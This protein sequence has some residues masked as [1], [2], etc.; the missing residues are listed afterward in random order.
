MAGNVWTAEQLDAIRH[1]GGA[2]LASAAAGSGKTAT[3]AA[4]CASLVLDLPETEPIRGGRADCS[5]NELL[6]VTFTDDASAEMSHRIATTIVRYA[7]ENPTQHNLRQ[8]LLAPAAEVSTLHGFCVRVLRQHGLAM[9]LQPDFAVADDTEANRHRQQAFSVV[10]RKHYGGGGANA[11]GFRLLVE[12]YCDGTL[13]WL[14]DIVKRVAAIHGVVPDPANWDA[15]SLEVIEELIGADCLKSPVIARG[16]AE[17]ATK[18]ETYGAK[19]AE[20]A[21]SAKAIGGDKLQRFIQYTAGWSE[22]LLTAA[23]HVRKSDLASAVHAFSQKPQGNRPAKTKLWPI[24]ATCLAADLESFASGSKFTKSGEALSAW[25]VSAIRRDANKVLPYARQ[26]LAVTADYEAEYARLKRAAGVVDFNDLERFT[27]QLLEV[28]NEETGRATVRDA[29]RRKYKHVLVDE[30]QDINGVQA[31]ILG[32]LCGPEGEVAGAAQFAVGD[33]KQSIYRFRLADPGQFMEMER[34]YAAGNGG[35]LLHMSDNFRSREPVLL[36]VNELFGQL[37]VGGAT[38]IDYSQGHS[39]KAGAAYPAKDGHAVQ[40][41]VLRN[42]T[43][44]NAGEEQVAEGEQPEA[45]AA[46]GSEGDTPSDE[47]EIIL[48]VNLLKE[49]VGRTKVLDKKTGEMRLLE[50]GDCAILL[51]AVRAISLQLG[52]VLRGARIPFVNR[53]A[54]PLLDQ[55]EVQDVLGLLRLATGESEETLWA[56]LLRGPLA[57]LLPAVEGEATEPAQRGSDVDGLLLK[58]APVRGGPGLAAVLSAVAKGEECPVLTGDELHFLQRMVGYVGRLATLTRTLDAAGMLRQIYHDTGYDRAV[59]AT[60]DGPQ[61]RANLWE[62]QR[63]AEE[64]RASGDRHADAP[65]FVDYLMSS[66]P[67]PVVPQLDMSPSESTSEFKG[68]LTGR[69]NAVAVMTVHKSKG[70]EFP[71][72]IVL[73]MG[74]KWNLRD[75]GHDVLCTREEGL[76]M[77]VY[78]PSIPARYSWPQHLLVGEAMAARTIAEELRLLYVAMTRAREELHLIGTGKK[79]T[80]KDLQAAA[81]VSAAAQPASLKIESDE[82]VLD[83]PTALKWFDT[84]LAGGGRLGQLIEVHRETEE[85]PWRLVRDHFNPQAIS[86]EVRAGMPHVRQANVA[87]ET[88]RLFANNLLK[89]L[90]FQYPFKWATHAPAAISVTRLAKGDAELPVSA[91][92]TP[93]ETGTAVLSESVPDAGD[94]E[95]LTKEPAGIPAGWAV[96]RK[97]LAANGQATGVVPRLAATDRGTATHLLLEHVAT[98][99]DISDADVLRLAEELKSRGLLT[100]AEVEAL[101][102]SGIRWVVN[103]ECGDL[104]RSGTVLKE[105]PVYFPAEG[106]AL[107]RLMTELKQPLPGRGAGGGGGGDGGGSGGGVSAVMGRD[108]PM[109]RGRVDVVID[110]PAGLIVL[111]YKTDGIGDNLLKQRTDYYRPQLELYA[112]ALKS[113]SGRPVVACYLAFL[114]PKRLVRL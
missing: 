85:R 92:S 97:L 41:H 22:V 69:P 3:L 110:T 11:E 90:N 57:V 62:L 65:R 103:S 32:H 23:G 79:P 68:D 74:K 27:L 6:V 71:L 56:A 111:D 73:R 114:T 113:L 30:Y 34:Q 19:L 61:R 50:Y 63:L 80:K 12:G 5:V 109:V 39:L 84:L 20:I 58:L 18:Y 51:R 60:M 29:L 93:R 91:N 108:R 102:I 105:L 43:G 37:M 38:D 89:A 112:D 35:R 100:P 1:R 64:A 75:P 87:D 47:R 33:V 81:T 45:G 10:A 101:D 16:L 2:A 9:G 48:A 59:L 13:T 96:P 72:V 7:E 70:L 99:R 21:A 55:P 49:R 66:D 8:A 46:A 53:D 25:D 107:E 4:R 31:S 95:P 98:D 54:P 78:D 86:A 52:N 40:L 26:L 83:H 17:I 88:N 15:K 42:M 67:G 104:L 82:D 94:V 28:R 24:A 76:A 44:A 106:P 14:F 36:A 77:R